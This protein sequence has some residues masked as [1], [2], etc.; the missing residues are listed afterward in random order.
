MSVR[1]ACTQAVGENGAA[2][3]VAK[4]LPEPGCPA[5]H[6]AGESQVIAQGHNYMGRNYA[7]RN[8]VG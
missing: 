6:A 2:E 4:S 5:A 7:G 3:A 1:T 8:Y